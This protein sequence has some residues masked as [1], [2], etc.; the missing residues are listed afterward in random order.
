MKA[1]GLYKG[2][3]DESP[4]AMKIR[5]AQT[6]P[7]HHERAARRPRP[8]CAPAVAPLLKGFNRSQAG[9]SRPA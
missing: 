9:P 8:C 3:M 7:E 1:G 2:I 4:E 6:L 5:L